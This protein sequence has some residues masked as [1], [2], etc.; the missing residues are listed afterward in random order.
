MNKRKKREARRGRRERE[1][2]ETVV[3]EHRASI[4]CFSTYFS[5]TFQVT[6]PTHSPLSD[7]LS[8]HANTSSRNTT[9]ENGETNWW[10]GFIRHPSSP[11]RACWV[12]KAS[13]S[14]LLLCQQGV[15]RRDSSS[16]GGQLWVGFD[17][18]MRTHYVTVEDL[19]F[20][21]LTVCVTLKV[22]FIYFPTS[23]L[24]LQTWMHLW[25]VKALLTGAFKFDKLG[26]Q[27]LL[28]F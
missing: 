2:I 9:V 21:D 6:F 19:H 26:I 1:R 20:V 3:E 5:A 28:H 22:V 24:L 12:Q 7:T 27:G 18:K 14:H 13:T 17:A 25:E 10:P 23:F 16:E 4:F 11:Q 8:S 15:N